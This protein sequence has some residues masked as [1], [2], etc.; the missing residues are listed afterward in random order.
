MSVYNLNPAKYGTHNILSK[1]IGDN[2]L[3]LDVG[4]NKGYLLRLAPNNIFYGI[5]SDEN[6]LEIAK[7]MYKRVYNID[8]NTNYRD[9]KETIKFDVIVFGDILEHLV[10]PVDVLKYFSDNYLKDKGVIIMSLPNVAHFSIRIKLLLGKFDYTDTGIL[11][12]THL[13]LYTLNTAKK[14]V[15]NIGLKV[16]KIEFSSNNFGFLFERFPFLGPI[17]GFNIICLCGK[18]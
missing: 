16:K 10:Y 6:D 7:T 17:L 15:N 1:H 8:L 9:F 4:C 18:Y 2:R 11:D 12:K 14:L 5:D 13:H 3:V